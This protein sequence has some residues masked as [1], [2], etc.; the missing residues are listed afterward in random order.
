VV[1]VCIYNYFFVVNIHAEAGGSNILKLSALSHQ[2]TEV[3]FFDSSSLFS[4]CFVVGDSFDATFEF[5]MNDVAE[6]VGSEET[7][8]RIII[9]SFE[10]VTPSA[11]N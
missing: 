6:L 8:G 1:E 3:A 9:N 7:R 5:S 10:F 4:F 11:N 2:G